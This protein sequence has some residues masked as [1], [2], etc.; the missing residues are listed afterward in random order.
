MARRTARRRSKRTRRIIA[1]CWSLAAFFALGYLPTIMLKSPVISMTA[2]ACLIIPFGS[3]SG[4]LKQAVFRG[5][6][7]GCAAGVGVWSALTYGGQ[8]SGQ[9]TSLALVY[10]AATAA[11]CAAVSVLFCHL[12]KK[13]RELGQGWT[14]GG[15]CG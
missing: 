8:L 10:I 13:R 6:G 7:L 2:S 11:M 12:V 9:F 5:L 1:A 4:R 14:G 15:D 3:R